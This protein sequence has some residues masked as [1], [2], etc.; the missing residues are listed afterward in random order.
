MW[1]HMCACIFTACK[2]PISSM[3]AHC[4]MQLWHV[5]LHQWIHMTHERCTS[6]A[7]TWFASSHVWCTGT[8]TIAIGNEMYLFCSLSVS[9]YI[10][11]IVFCCLWNM[12]ACSCWKHTVGTRVTLYTYLFSCLIIWTLLVESLMHFNYR[13]I[14]I[15]CKAY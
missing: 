13:W 4:C 5:H 10:V 3:H 11:I 2:T 12:W 9:L 6:R 14:S 7:H 8:V 15:T 1:V